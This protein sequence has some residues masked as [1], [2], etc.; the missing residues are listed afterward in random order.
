M[1]V[2]SFLIKHAKLLQVLAVTVLAFII[3]MVLYFPNYTKLKKL[4]QANTK[5]ERQI[6]QI[7][8]EISQLKKTLI[9]IGDDPY[10]Y[11]KFARDELGVARENEI[12][13]DIE[14]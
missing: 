4:R 2:K 14:E 7:E 11:E 1:Q 12:V 13:I 9:R 5:M 8:K 6:E 10:I 3:F